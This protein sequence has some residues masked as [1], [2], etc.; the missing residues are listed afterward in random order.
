M[1]YYVNLESLCPVRKVSC[2]LCDPK[3]AFIAQPSFSSLRY[4]GSRG[5]LSSPGGRTGQK[6]TLM[7]YDQQ[8]FIFVGLK[9]GLNIACEI[10]FDR[11][12]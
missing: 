3:E 9:I 11:M 4:Y 5:L 2:F 1:T 8:D 12:Y 6:A 10:L 7:I